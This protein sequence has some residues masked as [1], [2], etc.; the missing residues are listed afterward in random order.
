MDIRINLIPPYRKEEIEKSRKLKLA[1]KFESGSFFILLIFLATVFSFNYVLDANLKLL[2]RYLEIKNR[3]EQFQEIIRLRDFFKKANANV[4]EAE[5]L[6]KDQLYWSRL[7]LKL[8][9][10][11]PAGIEV[12]K[13]AARNYLVNL[14]GR[15][16]TRE[17]LIAFKEKIE[18]NE[19]FSEINFP[20]S[21][22]ET[23]EGAD[24]LMSFKVKKECL[25]KR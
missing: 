19:C 10:L 12:K 2:S 18:K 9:E 7:F 17:N 13:V 5:K 22:L 15:A 11:S 6:E 8:S 23:K 20:L 4:A 3:G 21:N 16:N 14:S 1:W 24:F 25:K